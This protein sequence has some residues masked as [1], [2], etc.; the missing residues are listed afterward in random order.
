MLKY[1][2]IGE[3]IQNLPPHVEP[4]ADL[5]D[6]TVAAMAAARAGQR[7]K[8]DRRSRHDAGVFPLAKTLQDVGDLA[9]ARD[10]RNS[11]IALGHHGADGGPSCCRVGR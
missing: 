10:L 3:I 4:P 8:P 5:E 7:A 1:S 6:R 11:A 9:V 2:D